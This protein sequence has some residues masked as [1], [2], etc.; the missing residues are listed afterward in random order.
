MTEKK[1]SPESGLSG[2]AEQAWS[3]ILEIVK[4]RIP[5]QNFNTWL[6]PTSG[7]SIDSEV[8]L[9]CAPNKF[10]ANWITDKFLEI[11]QEAV[12]AVLGAPRQIEF[13]GRPVWG[14]NLST[15]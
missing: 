12:A 7:V 9:V 10:A 14:E 6:K 13:I 3:Q 1:T 4:G 2:S 11:I 8:F 5:L 15:S